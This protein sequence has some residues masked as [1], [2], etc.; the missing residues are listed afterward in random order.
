MVIAYFLVWKNRKTGINAEQIHE[1]AEKSLKEVIE[2]D[3]NFEAEGAL[4]KLEQLGTV[5]NEKGMWFPSPM[6][7]S[8]SKN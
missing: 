8:I 5:K 2:L 3:I 4:A 7:E 6:E 1:D